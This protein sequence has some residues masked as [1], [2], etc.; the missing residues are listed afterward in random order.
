MLFRESP[1]LPPVSA[2]DWKIGR[3]VVHA[4]ATIV[5]GLCAFA[6]QMLCAQGLVPLDGVKAIT[7]G[8]Y[9]TCALT[10]ADGVKC[11]GDNRFGQLGDNTLTQRLTPT[12]VV[13][14]SS[15]V[16]AIAAGRTGACALSNAGGVICWGTNDVIGLTSGIMAIAEGDLHTCALSTSGGVKCW[17]TNA[18]GELGDNTV[19]QHWTPA[20]VVGLTSGVTA[21]AAGGDQS[22]ALTNVGGVK[23][24]GWN[25]YG[26][27]GDNTLTNRLTPVDVVGLNGGVAAISA[28]FNQTCALT[29]AGGVRC[30]GDNRYGQLGDNTLTQRLTP[31]DVVGLS[32]GVT[33]ISAGGLHTCALTISGGVKCWGWN[34]RGG[35]GDNTLIQRTT[36]TDVVGLAN[37]VK[38]ISAGADHTCALT[39]AG[40]VKCWGWNLYGQLG[41]STQADRRTPVNVL[42]A[43]DA[44][45][46]SAPGGLFVGYYHEDPVTNPEDPS[47]GALYLN[48]PS[49]DSTFAGTMFFTYIGCQKL[50]AGGISGSKD[51]Q[52]LSGH[53]SGPVDNTLQSGSFGGTYDS[54]AQRYT[55]TY[56]VDAGKQFVDLRPCIQYYIAPNGTWE[57]VP[58]GVSVPSSFFVSI[59]GNQVSW[60]TTSGMVL[61]LIAIVDQSLATSATTSA[62]KWQTILSSSFTIADLSAFGQTLG[63]NDVVTVAIFDSLGRRTA[64]GSKAATTTVTAVEYHHASFDHYFITPVVSEIVLLD[65]R[66]PPFQ[67]W[68][69]TGLSF[70]VYAAATAPAGSVATCRFFND[71]FA[72]KSSHFYAPHGFGCETTISLFPDWTLEDSA[73][74]STMLPDANGACPAGTIPVYRLYNNG[75]GGAP[76]HRYTTSLATRSAMLVQGW[77]PE[78]SGVIGVI[79]CV[80]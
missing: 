41:D 4:G 62:V 23:C 29:T 59:N 57:V 13:G 72:P 69:R 61:T 53:W 42:N 31:V 36:P 39:T 32:S 5:V 70:D 45:P 1:H 51:K 14:L 24:W 20:D 74:F 16:M 67:D 55:G 73:L 54:A 77:I 47:P 18:A 68:S 2:Q 40:S 44:P 49:A 48:L 37:G 76:N 3:R 46:S 43:S 22:C 38:A 11:W 33:A 79:E 50:S 10:A 26:Q 12:D 17:G 64:F 52:S 7:T 27:V 9:S 21:I 6:A 25:A 65:A 35:L 58:I 71:H 56:T 60:P 80:P 30:W 63:P 15:G 28:G 19:I 75:Q 78:G 66:A 8:G 34:G